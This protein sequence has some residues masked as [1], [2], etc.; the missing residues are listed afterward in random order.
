MQTK[1][2]SELREEYIDRSSRDLQIVTGLESS[3]SWRM[4][5]EDQTENIKRI[6]SCWQFIPKSDEKRLDDLRIAK[7]AGLTIINLLESYK[8]D[9][10]KCQQ[11]VKELEDS[12][13]GTEEG[14]ENGG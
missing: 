2:A 1:S 7:M 4:I 6:D 10:I 8:S 12:A 11:A 5:I 14:L 9:M 13:E 3:D